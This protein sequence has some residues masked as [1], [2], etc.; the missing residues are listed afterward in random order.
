MDRGRPDGGGLR[1]LRGGGGRRAPGERPGRARPAATLP[2]PPDPSI[3][4]D[5]GTDG[6][7]A[8]WG[9]TFDDAPQ[10]PTP[11][12][13]CVDPETLSLRILAHQQ[14]LFLVL[15]PPPASP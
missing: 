4:F 14:Q 9:G 12:T 15:G 8:L 10:G 3:E 6:Q 2:L 13:A 5:D 11:R 1:V 7:L